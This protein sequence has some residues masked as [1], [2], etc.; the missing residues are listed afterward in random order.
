MSD[1]TIIPAWIGRRW[2]LVAG[3]LAAA[4]AVVMV[5]LVVLVQYQRN[6][7]L[8][9]RKT[10]ARSYVLRAHMQH[11]FSLVQD[12][13]TG[14][15]GFMLTGEE[16]FLEP[17]DHAR[18]K[19]PNEI[20]QLRA[21]ALHAPDRVHADRIDV[22]V[23][24]KLQIAAR[25]VALRREAAP[26]AA[27][28]S[29]RDGQGRK[30]MDEIRAELARWD[31]EEENELA[32]RLAAA[33]AAG[34]ALRLT[35]RSLAAGV[36]LIIFAGGWGAV[37]LARSREQA[38]AA[39]Q[40]KSRFLAM[41]SHELRTP[42]NG[43]L[44]MAHALAASPLDARQHGYVDVIE[45]SGQSLL[46]ILNDILDL[47][48]IEAGRLE[49]EAIAF[50]L[51][52]LIDA[53]VALWNAPAAEKGLRLVVE[54]DAL[55]AWVTGD[56]T[57]L[58]QVLTNLLSNALKFTSRGEIR[59]NVRYSADQRIQ[60]QVA[61]TGAGMSPAVQA[62]LFRDFSQGE[63]STGRKFGG[64]GLGLSISRRLCRMMGGDLEAQSIEGEGSTFTGSIAAPVAE[65][66]VEAA[67]AEVQDDLPSLRIL[68]VDD[69]ASNRA[70]VEAL[71][72]ALGLP[73]ILAS[74]GAEALEVL[75]A[76][77]V[78]L[79]LMDVNMPV[80]NGLE[81]LAAIREG[82]AG[83]P[84]VRVVA[85]TADAMTGDRERYLAKGFDGHLSKPI[86]P[87]ALIE[88]LTEAVQSVGA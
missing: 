65:P 27:A 35:L 81:A 29:V 75:R 8:E 64:T 62:R 40:A 88:A 44:G 72:H 57:R 58:R 51:P 21:S 15:R 38:E 69:N 50:C 12:V 9:T 42:L 71:L 80:M 59:F 84:R 23:R 34:R 14:A 47:S 83:D 66:P 20:A 5:A 67:D 26:Q 16:V 33:D 45:T 79:V 63:V 49:I 77:P 13:E 78:D 10:V 86:V 3:A 36:V 6:E 48:K 87:Q 25:H 54:L 41:M 56:P 82:Q 52:E 74:D 37:A 32:Q 28:L 18:A 2:R 1:K 24:R 11:V 30:V 76:T 46:A 70:V 60:F 43:V 4:L 68:A 61:D 31:A 19:L 85:L 53:I 17:Y 22:L 39:N 7:D 55:P 73:V